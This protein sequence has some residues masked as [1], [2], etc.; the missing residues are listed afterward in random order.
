MGFFSTKEALNK[1]INKLKAELQ[2]NSLIIKQQSEEIK[3]LSRG[4]PLRTLS[5]LTE[6]KEQRRKWN[7]TAYFK[8][9]NKEIQ[10]KENQNKHSSEEIPIKTNLSYV[11]EGEV[12][13]EKQKQVIKSSQQT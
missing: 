8:R 1:E 10:K 5:Y 3:R 9:K 7:K 13:S 6:T 4:N 11:P 2:E 12:M